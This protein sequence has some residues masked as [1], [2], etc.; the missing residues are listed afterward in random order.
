MQF[1][2]AT[3]LSL[4]AKNRLAVPTKYRQAILDACAGHLVLTVHPHGCLMLYPQPAWEPV[5]KDLMSRP[6]FDEDVSM[7][8]R[9]VVG[10]A[11]DLEMDGTG[12][13]LVSNVLKNFAGLDKEV[14]LV[15]QLA[16]FEI[17][18]LDVWNEKMA[19][20]MPTT[21]QKFV[22]PAALSDFSL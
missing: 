8:Q 21:G 18:N 17:W 7:M 22:M 5:E 13:I 2:G 11:E 20:L 6:S 3:T 12:R 15:G 14:M 10:M 1:R 19:R 16:R 4:D 9:T